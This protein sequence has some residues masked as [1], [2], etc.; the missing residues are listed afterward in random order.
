[1][2]ALLTLRF[3]DELLVGF[4]DAILPLGRTSAEGPELHDADVPLPLSDELFAGG[5]AIWSFGRFL[6]LL[7]RLE[8]ELLRFLTL[9]RFGFASFQRRLEDFRED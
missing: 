1:M 7:L 4:S 3:L 5:F 2:T 9:D 8:V 6:L